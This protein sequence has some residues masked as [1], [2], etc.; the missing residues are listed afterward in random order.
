MG[1]EVEGSEV[2]GGDDLRGVALSREPP[3]RLLDGVAFFAAPGFDGRGGTPPL[4][5]AAAAASD[6]PADDEGRDRVRFTAA[7]GGRGL[8][9]PPLPPREGFSGWPAAEAV[10]R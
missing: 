6:V 1:A 9:P 10:N 4:L 8:F 2:E 3:L 7:S 5:T